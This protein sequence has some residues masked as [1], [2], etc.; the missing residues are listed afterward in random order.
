MREHQLPRA[1]TQAP[2]GIDTIVAL[3]SWTRHKVARIF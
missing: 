2:S 3:V 1:A